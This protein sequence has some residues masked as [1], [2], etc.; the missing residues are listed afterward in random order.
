MVDRARRTIHDLLRPRSLPVGV[1]KV[2]GVV[3]TVLVVIS[4]ATV[5]RVVRTPVLRTPPATVVN[6]VTQLNPIT[7]SEVIVPTTTEEIVEAVTQH[8]GPIAVGGGRYS[9]GGQTATENALHIDMRQFNHILDFYPARKLITVQA[10]TRWRQIQEHIDPAD[11]SVKIMQTYADFTVGGSVSVNVHG[12]Y[13]GLGPLVR[14]IAEGRARRRVSGRGEPH[15]K[16][17]Y[18]LRRHRRIRWA[19][20]D[21]GGDPRAGGQRKGQAS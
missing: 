6:D 9:M 5:W 18:L 3:A 8:P 17:R 1:K 15:P 20:S 4:V 2:V 21:H 16:L 19:R 14:S 7:V 10:G 11:L 13:V 12:R